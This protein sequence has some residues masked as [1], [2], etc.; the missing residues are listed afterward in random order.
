MNCTGEKILTTV[1]YKIVLTLFDDIS[2]VTN[3]INKPCAISE[4]TT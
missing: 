3:D 4:K 2:I 1:K